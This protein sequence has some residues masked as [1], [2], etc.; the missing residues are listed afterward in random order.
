MTK[1]YSKTSDKLKQKTENQTR[2]YYLLKV[3]PEAIK[4]EIIARSLSGWTINTQSSAFGLHKPAIRGVLNSVERQKMVDKL[5]KN[6]HKYP[7]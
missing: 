5:G 4:Q 7:Y 3:I 1:K 2:F 6:Y